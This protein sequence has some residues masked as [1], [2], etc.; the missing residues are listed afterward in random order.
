M[1]V[2]RY[3]TQ[4]QKQHQCI[5]FLVFRITLTSS[6]PISDKNSLGLVDE[7]ATSGLRFTLLQLICPCFLALIRRYKYNQT[8][9]WE[10]VKDNGNQI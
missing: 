1:G 10:R 5:P 7:M 4:R 6:K 2:S 3:V 8:L 9:G